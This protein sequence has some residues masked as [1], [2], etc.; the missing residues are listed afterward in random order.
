MKPSSATESIEVKKQTPPL[1]TGRERPVSKE[2]LCSTADTD[3]QA[4]AITD[5]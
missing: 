2:S 3:K 1:V 5:L 4:V